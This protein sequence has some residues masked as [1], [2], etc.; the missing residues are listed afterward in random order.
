VMKTMTSSL[1]DCEICKVIIYYEGK[2]IDYL[3]FYHTR[4]K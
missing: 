3:K 2:T 4:A 1:K